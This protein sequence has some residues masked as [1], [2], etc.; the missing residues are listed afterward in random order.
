MLRDLSERVSKEDKQRIEDALED[1]SALFGVV[2][3]LREMA[4]VACRPKRI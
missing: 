1:V 4:D 2:A 3:R